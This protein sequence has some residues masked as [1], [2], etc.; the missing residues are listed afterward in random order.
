MRGG[1]EE[2]NEEGLE[3]NEEHGGEEEEKE[4]ERSQGY[5]QV[6]S[7]VTGSTVN[8]R[9]SFTHTCEYICIQL[10]KKQNSTRICVLG[11]HCILFLIEIACV[12]AVV[13]QHWVFLLMTHKHDTFVPFCSLSF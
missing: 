6:W 10:Q 12:V 7:R 13:C 1:E 9:K 8:W 3:T 2:E 5:R 11:S 4:E